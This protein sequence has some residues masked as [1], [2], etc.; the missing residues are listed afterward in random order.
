VPSSTPSASLAGKV[1]IITGGTAGI[2]RATAELMIARGARVML[3]GRDLERAKSIH[4][5]VN[6]GV[7]RFKQHDA[8]D[9]QGWAEVVA[10]TL[11]AFGRIDILV[12]NAGRIIVK[13][14]EQLSFGDMQAMTTANIISAF[15]GTRAVWPHFVSSGGGSI[16]NVGALMG[17]MA[18]GLG[19]AYSAAKGATHALT[20]T[21]AIEGAPHN[22]RVNTILP[23]L[24]W[25]DGW[26]RM[27][28]P[29]PD[30]TK[31]NL[32]PSIPMGRVG[33][34][35]EIAQA[36]CFLASDEA[37]TITGIDMAIDGGKSAG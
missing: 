14:L 6:S 21:A 12:N 34:P 30:K 37:R 29:E 16:I 24:I 27:A 25:S 22:I 17:E 23:G 33:E 2:G 9:E 1:A 5:W 15:L 3:T 18:N 26:K 19:V 28:G 8:A 7:A 32:A 11:S 10:D 13:P 31:A 4:P 35:F 36:I 20:K